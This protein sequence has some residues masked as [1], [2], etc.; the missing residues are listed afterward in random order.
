MFGK[1]RNSQIL[2]KINKKARLLSRL[3]KYAV[4]TCLLGDFEAAQVYKL[5][6][7][8]GNGFFVELQ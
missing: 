4:L 1:A 6:Q 7:A 5:L 2:S 3:L 8:F